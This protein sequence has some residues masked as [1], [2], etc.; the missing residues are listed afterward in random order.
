MRPL[1]A[2][3]W[4]SGRRARNTPSPFSGSPARPAVGRP[5]AGSPF[6]F[7]SSGPAL[8]L[9]K[10]FWKVRAD[11]PDNGVRVRD[12]DGDRVVVHQPRSEDAEAL[13]DLSELG[14]VTA[15]LDED[16]GLVDVVLHDRRDHSASL[17]LKML[18]Q[19][20]CFDRLDRVV[21]EDHVLEHAR[22]SHAV[23]QHA[24]VAAPAVQENRAAQQ[25]AGRNVDE[26]HGECRGEELTLING[27]AGRDDARQEEQAGEKSLLQPEVVSVEDLVSGGTRG[28]F[29]AHGTTDYPVGLLQVA[30]RN[31]CVRRLGASV[32]ATRRPGRATRWARTRDPASTSG[33]GPRL[34]TGL[35]PARQGTPRPAQW[36]RSAG[37]G[38]PGCREGRPGADRARSSK[39]T[40]RP[41]ANRTT[42]VR[43]LFP[44]RRCR[45]RSGTSSTR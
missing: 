45:Q 27:D 9:S 5:R 37:D 20:Q 13:F 12:W 23:V 11:L 4:R 18:P 28:G 17:V 33:R 34:S 19:G 30:P 6:P 14:L 42:A 16:R 41:P 10:S 2:R 29:G 1:S 43:C 15:N 31:G 40:R 3:G 35:L 36:S 21:V 8:V 38:A 32:I 7:A 22:D 39:Q 44:S 26:P 25:N 24:Q